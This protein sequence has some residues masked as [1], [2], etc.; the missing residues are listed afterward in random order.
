M[1]EQQSI[2]E[3]LSIER[4]FC[5][6]GASPHG[7][8]IPKGYCNCGDDQKT[9]TYSEAAST[10]SPY[11]A[12]PYTTDD[13][14]TVTFHAASTA[15]PSATA[16]PSVTCGEP[17]ERWFSSADGYNFA[18]DFC[19]RGEGEVLMPRTDSG[20]A[21]AYVQR[22]NANKDPLITIYAYLDNSC[23]S[24]RLTHLNGDECVKALDSIMHQ[25]KSTL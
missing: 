22:F 13:G 20:F 9:L 12:C 23:R 18:S 3:D 15:P 19:N 14:P 24:K 1:D 16:T 7:D 6:H 10:A 5:L 4:P 21:S 8:L 17:R 2:L 25:C 11:N